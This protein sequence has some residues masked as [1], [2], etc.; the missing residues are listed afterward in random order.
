[1]TSHQ[2][3]EDEYLRD[4][5]RALRGVDLESVADRLK[6][7]AAAGIPSEQIRDFD[8]RATEAARF[9]RSLERLGALRAAVSITATDTTEEDWR[10]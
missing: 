2:L 6:A 5:T 9:E 1:M 10:L 8:R 7:Y 4:M 3:V